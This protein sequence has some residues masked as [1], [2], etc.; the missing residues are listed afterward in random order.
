MHKMVESNKTQE[1]FE[2]LD[3]TSLSREAKDD[4]ISIFAYFNGEHPAVFANRIFL[5]EGDPGVGKTFLTKKLTSY[6]NKPVIFLGQTEIFDKAKKVKSIEEILKVL[7]SFD[8]G[9]IYIDDLRYVFNFNE[10]EDLDNADRHKFMR[11]LEHFKEN[12]KK[13]VLIMTLNDSLFMDESWIDRID[14]HIKFDLPS[15]DN[16]L[17]FLNGNFSQYINPEDLVYLSENTVGYNYRDLPQ[18]IKLAYNYGKGTISIDSIKDAL[19]S[20]TPS[21]LSMFNIKQGVKLKLNDLFLSDNLRKELSRIRLTIEKRKE[22]SENNATRQTLLIFEGPSGTGKTYSALALA[23]ELGV[24]LVKIGVREFHSRRLG[25]GAIFDCI[26][27]FE[28]AIVLIDDAD[29]IINGSALSFNDGGPLN[30]DLNS[31]LDE[32]NKA[33]LVILSVNDSRRLGRALRDRFKIIQFNNPG[34]IE[35][36]SYMNDILKKS[37]IKFNMSDSD[38]ADL[39]EGMNYRDMQRFWND[40]IFFA[41]ENELKLLEKQDVLHIAEKNKYIKPR[42]DMIG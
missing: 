18:V 20:Y 10:F 1:F 31:H 35:R 6:L 5:F 26:S 7:E 32:L 3:K 17:G 16:K 30:S 29:K 27:R 39:T 41:V 12:N 21:S 22:F 28:D 13:T 33:S 23:G 38:F 36:S 11:V 34:A 40:C 8:E 19:L 24:P 2:Y 9:V 14:S 4:I 25:L 37:K 15:N 42:I